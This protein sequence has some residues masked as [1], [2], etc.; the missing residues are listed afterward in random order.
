MGRGLL[1]GWIIWLGE[2]KD[3]FYRFFLISEGKEELMV[4]GS[5]S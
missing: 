4:F 2:L 1:F 3:R 5:W